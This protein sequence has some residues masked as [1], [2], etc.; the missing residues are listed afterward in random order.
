MKYIAKLN[1][2]PARVLWNNICQT[3]DCQLAVL[4]S[5]IDSYNNHFTLPMT[6]KCIQDE[7]GT[8]AVQVKSGESVVVLH[9]TMACKC[10]LWSYE[11]NIGYIF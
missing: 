3:K 2:L 1:S 8:D 9:N 10:H 11:E 6:G 5:L 4:T 7:I